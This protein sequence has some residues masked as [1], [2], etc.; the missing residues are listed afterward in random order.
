MHILKVREYYK[1]S[2]ETTKLFLT[3]PP[4]KSSYT[5]QYFKYHFVRGTM[6]ANFQPD[7]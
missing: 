7:I 1:I 3:P 2:M 4:T 6:H 5:F